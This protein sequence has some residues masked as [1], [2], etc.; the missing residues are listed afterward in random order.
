M[1]IS[2]HL[3]STLGRGLPPED[4]EEGELLVEPPIKLPVEALNRAT[5]VEESHLEEGHPN[6]GHPKEG[7]LEEGHP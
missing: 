5:Q 7:H 6:E 1:V 3:E 2:L 4:P